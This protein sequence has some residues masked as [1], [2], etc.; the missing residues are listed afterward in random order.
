MTLSTLG[1]RRA[2]QTRVDIAATAVWEWSITKILNGGSSRNTPVNN[3]SLGRIKPR[4]E[5]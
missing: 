2:F 3:L 5:I 1:T 4:T